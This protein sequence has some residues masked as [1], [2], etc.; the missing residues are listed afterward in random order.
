MGRT[1]IVM[2]RR[3]GITEAGINYVRGNTT[4]VA[5]CDPI[6]VCWAMICSDDVKS[7][8]HRHPRVGER[9]VGRARAVRKVWMPSFEGVT[10][11]SSTLVLLAEHFRIVLAELR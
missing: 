10:I 7:L 4:S 8:S 5:A 9:R 1:M 6:V 11:R 3:Y 2:A